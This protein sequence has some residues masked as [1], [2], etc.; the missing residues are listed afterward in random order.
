[1]IQL[2]LAIFFDNVGP[3]IKFD[4]NTHLKLKFMIEIYY[5]D[6]VSGMWVTDDV[7]PTTPKFTA[8]SGI[9]VDMPDEPTEYDFAKLFFT[10]DELWTL[11]VTE[12]NPGMRHSTWIAMSPHCHSIAA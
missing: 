6:V 7:Q 8:T 1:M 3:S 10:V 4:K 9:D 11:L 2:E 5:A 12:T